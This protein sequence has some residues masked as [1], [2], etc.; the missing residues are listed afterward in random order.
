MSL[1]IEGI[2][3]VGAAASSAVGAILNWPFAFGIAAFLAIAVTA[4]HFSS[5]RGRGT[6]TAGSTAGQNSAEPQS[7]IKSHGKAVALSH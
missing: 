6:G 5:R 4:F 2:G 3:A 7:Q 1:R